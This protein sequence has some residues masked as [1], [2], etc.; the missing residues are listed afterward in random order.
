MNHWETVVHYSLQNNRKTCEKKRRPR[1]VIWLVRKKGFR[2]KR[3]AS[4]ETLWVG[5]AWVV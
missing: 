5:R 4:A 3:M 2:Q 1:P